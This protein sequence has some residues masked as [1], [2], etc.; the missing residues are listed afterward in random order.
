MLISSIDVK[1]FRQSKTAGYVC[2]CITYVKC[3]GINFE[4]SGQTEKR[5][6]Q[7]FTILQHYT[8]F[9]IRFKLMRNLR[10][11]S[12][13]MPMVL[14][15]WSYFCPLLKFLFIKY[16]LSSKCWYWV[17]IIFQLY[18]TRTFWA[19]IYLPWL[20]RQ[21]WRKQNNADIK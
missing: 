7:H 21:N 16:V 18:N 4:R 19:S 12:R 11:Q 3:W 8:V 13:G 14:Q 20:G 17:L 6:S 10:K 2:F 9:I 15:L 5:S 1:L